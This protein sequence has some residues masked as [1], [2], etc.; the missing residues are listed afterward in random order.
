[1]KNAS[2]KFYIIVMLALS[3]FNPTI[4]S[5]RAERAKLV[6]DSFQEINRSIETPTGPSPKRGGLD[7]DQKT[8]GRVVYC[9]TGATALILGYGF[10]Y[11]CRN[12]QNNTHQK[13][14]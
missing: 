10:G 3:I 11:I 9:C 14:E 5:T 13:S 4:C 6:V 1:M 2:Q 8:I 12:S 7:L